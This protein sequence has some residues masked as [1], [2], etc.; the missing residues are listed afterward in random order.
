M[1]R[2]ST[3][4]P[5]AVLLALAMVLF[6]QIYTAV[7]DFPP[8]RMGADRLLVDS[9]SYL[10]M[11]L[12]EELWRTGDWFEKTTPVINAPYGDDRPWPRIMDALLI[13]TALPF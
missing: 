11:H 7:Q 4:H 2:L 5:A 6:V 12:V 10:R 3:H 8:Q 9:D 1:A 13:G